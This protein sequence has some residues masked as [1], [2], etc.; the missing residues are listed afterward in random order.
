M[1][2]EQRLEERP[3]NDRSVSKASSDSWQPGLYDAKLGF[4]A[5]A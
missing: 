3:M 5:H 4:N 1:I 2:D